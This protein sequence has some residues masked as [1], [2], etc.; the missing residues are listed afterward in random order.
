MDPYLCTPMYGGNSETLLIDAVHDT[1]HCSLYR[2][3]VI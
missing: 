2:H 1:K 3:S